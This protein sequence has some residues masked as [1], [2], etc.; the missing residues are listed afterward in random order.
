MPISD[1]INYWR[2]F[3]FPTLQRNPAITSITSVDVTNNFAQTVDWTPGDGNPILDTSTA[4][5]MNPEAPARRS[6]LNRFKRDASL[7]SA[8]STT[9][10][11][12]TPATITTAPTMSPRSCELHEED[13]DQGI[14]QAYCLCDNSV[15]LTPLSVPLTGHQSDSCAYTAM[16]ATA[17]ISISTQEAVFRSDC[18]IQLN[19]PTCTSTIQGCTPT[20]AAATPTST[21]VVHLSNN[22]VHVGDVNKANNGQDF[23]DEVKAKLKSVCPDPAPGQSGFC[24]TKTKPEI[25]GITTITLDPA[26][27]D[28]VLTQGKLVSTVQDASCRSSGERD[29]MLAA[30]VGAFQ[31]SSGKSCTEMDYAYS[32]DQHTTTGCG[33][34]PGKRSSVSGTIPNLICHSKVTVCSGAD[35]ISK[36]TL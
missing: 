14:N 7:C 8:T 29:R 2:A 1:D 26:S 30:A 33:T 17:T 5:Q 32:V 23:R 6:R 36:F 24:D 3:V 25:E 10:D 16:P 11:N 31:Q 19:A 9:T 12:P 35:H 4:S 15:T 20:G 34:P 22:T 13:P 27:E 18:K 28:G 21:F